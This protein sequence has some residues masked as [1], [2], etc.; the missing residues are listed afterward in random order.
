[1]KAIA[2]K[3]KTLGYKLI[4]NGNEITVINRFGGTFTGRLDE[5]GKVIPISKLGLGSLILAMMDYRHGFL[6]E[7]K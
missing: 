4:I 3:S 5:N 1:M 2:F 6:E 7:V